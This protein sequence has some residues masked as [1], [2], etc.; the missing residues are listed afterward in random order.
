MLSLPMGSMSTLRSGR[1]A[2][3]GRG[4]LLRPPQITAV[5]AE[6]VRVVGDFCIPIGRCPIDGLPG[7]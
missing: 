4:V 3:T 5:N 6:E 7:D 2:V 1:S